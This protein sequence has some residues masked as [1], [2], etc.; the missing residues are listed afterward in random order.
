MNT[1]V[2]HVTDILSIIIATLVAVSAW[3]LFLYEYL[4]NGPVP[5]WLM[6]FAALFTFL[7]VMTLFGKEK[8]NAALEAMK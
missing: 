3:G 8:V 6:G 5:S 2:D 7:A 4:T 1:S